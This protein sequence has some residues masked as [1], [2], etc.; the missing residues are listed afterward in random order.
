MIFF[1]FAGFFSIARVTGESREE[2]SSEKTIQIKLFLEGS[3]N[4][5]RTGSRGIVNGTIAVDR[6]Y[7]L[8]G[9]YSEIFSLASS[10]FSWSALTL[11]VQTLKHHKLAVHNSPTMCCV[12][13]DFKVHAARY[14]TSSLSCRAACRK[15]SPAAVS[16][17]NL[18]VWGSNL[19][20]IEEAGQWVLFSFFSFCFHQLTKV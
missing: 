10:R 2:R 4:T 17:L 9:N 5:L 1:D 13:M 20:Y 12:F 7:I 3:S 6:I 8:W 11:K 19:I 16:A 18:K 15:P 14:Q